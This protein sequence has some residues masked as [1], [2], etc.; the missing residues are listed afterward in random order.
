MGL[1]FFLQRIKRSL[2]I[3]FY[4]GYLLILK[5]FSFRRSIWRRRVEKENIGRGNIIILLLHHSHIQ[6]ELSYP[7]ACLM[8]PELETQ[9][10]AK[11]NLLDSQLLVFQYHDL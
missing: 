11:Q 5:P 9:D 4:I 2:R 10:Q 8:I 7:V 3:V 6:P 1:S